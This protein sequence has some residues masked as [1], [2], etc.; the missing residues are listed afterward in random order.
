MRIL[1]YI[2]SFFA[3]RKAIYEARRRLAAANRR[4]VSCENLLYVRTE[5]ANWAEHRERD[6]LEKIVELREKLKNKEQEHDL[7]FHQLHMLKASV[8]AHVNR[9]RVQEA[10]IYEQ[11]QHIEFL[12]SL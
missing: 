3:S 11:K 1:D 10:I 8:E 2:S 4:V 12:K 7:V 6:C 9:A 5:R